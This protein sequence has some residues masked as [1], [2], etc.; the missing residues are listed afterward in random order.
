MTAPVKNLILITGFVFAIILQANGQKHF[1][2]ALG[3]GF[4]ELANLAARY[5]FNQY[6]AGLSVGTS[7]VAGEKSIA[8]AGDF[9]YHFEGKSKYTTVKP[10]FAHTGLAF[11]RFENENRIINDAWVYIRAGRHF[12][13][14]NNLG[15]SIDAGLTK[16]VGFNKTIKRQYNS[17][18]LFDF[19]LLP[20]GTFQLYWRLL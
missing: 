11:R 13:F 4:P 16:R 2:V 8:I 18:N 15:V 9:Y 19:Q 7:F 20:A 14:T 6:K 5:Q 3:T 17:W 1:D 12:N 10:W